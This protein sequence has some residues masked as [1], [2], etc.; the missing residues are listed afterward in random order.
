MPPGKT[1]T[2]RNGLYLVEVLAKGALELPQTSQTIAKAIGLYLQ[3]DGKA[4]FL[5]TIIMSSNTEK[6]IRG[7]LEALLLLTSIHGAG[8]YFVCDQRRQAIINPES[9][10]SNLSARYTN[11]H[12][13]MLWEELTTELLDWSPTPWDATQTWHH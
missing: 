4:W 3:S 8:K 7:L 12:A 11:T 1:S 5:K 6:L 2:A 9:Y 10:N 13:Q